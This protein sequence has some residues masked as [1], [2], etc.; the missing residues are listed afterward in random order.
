MK[1]TSEGGSTAIIAC[2]TTATGCPCRRVWQ[3]PVDSLL[4]GGLGTLP[5]APISAAAPE[6]L[7]GVVR[8]MEAR[9]TREATPAEAGTLWTATYLLLGLRY[10]AEFATQ[11]LMGVRNMKES[12]TYQAIKAEGEALGR[13]QGAEK[14]REALF[15]LG[16]KRLGEPDAATR[17]AVEALDDLDRLTLLTERLLDVESWVELLAGSQT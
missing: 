17:A 10:P 16:S 9:I 4:Q 12:T 6:A 15:V 3:L 11:L 2:W 1:P 13:A 8:Q 5:L 7:P 14:L